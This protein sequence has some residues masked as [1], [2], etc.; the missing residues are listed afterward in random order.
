MG[1][2]FRKSISIIPGV[3]LNFSK[4]GMS[5]SSGVPGFRKTINTKGQ[6]TTTVGIPGTGLYYVDT[7]KAGNKQSNRNRNTQTQPSFS[8]SQPAA[9]Y[10]PSVTELD[11]GNNAESGY[12]TPATTVKQ[13]DT[14]TLKSIH[15]TADDTVDWT[16]I[17]V[18]PTA[19]DSSYNQDMWSYYY[20]VASD[21]LNGDIDTYLRLIYEVNPLDDLLEYGSNFEFGT[22]NPDFIE[23]EFTL[24]TDVL[25]QAYQTLS[26]REYNDLLQDFLCSLSIRIARDMFALLPINHTIIHAVMD[27]NTVLSVDFD[28]NTLSK[29]KYAFVDPSDTIK[30]F[31]FEMNFNQSSGLSPISRLAYREA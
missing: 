9:S 31:R 4:S 10:V 27:H 14:N 15:K 22:D 29:V 11:I 3:R 24:N 30:K 16:E 13:V 21:I 26:R 28:R 8:Q 19:P 23:V 5:V 17:L 6:V 1:L 2:R 20:S 7:K 25:S 18:S 12:D